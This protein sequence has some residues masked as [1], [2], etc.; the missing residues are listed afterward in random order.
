MHL[1]A[2]VVDVIRAHKARQAA[3]RLVVGPDWKDTAG[4]VFT[5]PLGTPVH[6]DNFYHC[7]D[8]LSNAA[9]LGH[10][11][12]HELRH[13]CASLLLAMLVPLEV[14][15]ESLGHS[16]I[17][18][19]KDVYGHLMAP[20]RAAAADAMGEALWGNASTSPG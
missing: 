5:T 13:S 4:L 6:P 20:A 7:M 14:V 17:R 2:P 18:V 8:R 15:S 10:W 12:P 11:S 3:E 9:G 16:S 19:T 1:P